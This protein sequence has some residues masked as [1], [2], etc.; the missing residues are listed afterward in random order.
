MAPKN[1]SPAKPKV[2]AYAFEKWFEHPS[3]PYALTFETDEATVAHLPYDDARRLEDS[4]GVVIPQG[5]FESIEFHDTWQGKRGVAKCDR[6][7]M[8]ER[9]RQ[10]RNLIQRGGWVC[11]LVE[12][13]VDELP[14]GDGY[15]THSVKNTDLC[16]DV[17]N[18]MDV[19]RELAVEGLAACHAVHNEFRNYVQQHGIAKTVFTFR[20]SPSLTVLVRHGDAPV[21]IEAVQQ[22]F[23]LPFV[24]T[25]TEFTLLRDLLSLVVKSVSDYRLKM[26]EETPPWTNELQFARE[27]QLIEQ[28]K[29]L[30]TEL[31]D[32]HLEIKHWQKYKRLL[33]GSGE[34]LR[35]DVVLT[36]QDFFSLTVDPTD[37]GREDFKILVE[38]SV[39]CMGESKGTNG[40]VK[41]EHI[42]QVDSH[43]E[44][45][46]L[47]HDIPG[48]LIINSHMDVLSI[49]DR[50]KTQI[51]KEQVIHAHSMNVT[52]TRTIDLLLLMRHLESTQD[53]RERLLSILKKG[54]GWL[55]ADFEEYRLEQN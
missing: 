45:A 18:G 10:V 51:A 1:S 32:A 16:K 7:R 15:R 31:A 6:N 39:A 30:E 23:F 25:R 17:L 42:N 49:P 21:G 55:R 11:F 26:N 46:G 38:N 53:R 35:Q 29:R 22:L 52:F 48:L 44:R 13:I 41:R 5:I 9:E 33:S 28:A 14:S 19:G 27:T 2:F 47:G 12:A 4:D 36:L 54:G 50:M 34:R 3:N 37:E 24:R 40:G 43:R 8:L 20:P